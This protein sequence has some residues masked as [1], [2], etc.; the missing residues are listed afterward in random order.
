MSSALTIPPAAP[1]QPAARAD[2]F[3]VPSR[4]E[5]E[6][7]TSIPDE[8]HVIGNVIWAFYEQLVE[9]IPEDVNIHVDYDGKDVEI[10]SPSALH[11]GEKKLWR[12]RT[13]AQAGQ[14]GNDLRSLAAW[15][16]TNATSS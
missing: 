6:R 8:R 15:S 16:P 1:S 13:R 11:D 14:P 7:M 12:S 3:P 9:S 5:L 4:D 2:L 10:M